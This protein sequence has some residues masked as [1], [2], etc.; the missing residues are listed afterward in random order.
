MPVAALAQ[1]GISGAT[2]LLADLSSQAQD[3]RGLAGLDRQRLLRCTLIGLLL[4]GPMLHV[5]FEKLERFSIVSKVL[6]PQKLV[7]S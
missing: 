3:G 2:F 7:N 1:A 6:L 4:H 5:F